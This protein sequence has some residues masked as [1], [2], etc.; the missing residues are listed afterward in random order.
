MPETVEELIERIAKGHPRDIFYS[1]IYRY[2]NNAKLPRDAFH[3]V[4]KTLA[5]KGIWVHG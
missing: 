4:C 1:D 3:Q 5:A 2:V